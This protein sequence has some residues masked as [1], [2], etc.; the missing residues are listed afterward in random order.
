MKK[1]LSGIIFLSLLVSLAGCKKKPEQPPITKISDGYIYTVDYLKYIAGDANAKKR[2]TEDAYLIGVVVADEVTGNLYKEVYLRDRNGK[3]AIHLS[4]TAGYS[5]FFVGDSLR[6]MLK[7]YDVAFSDGMLEIDSIDYEKSVVKFGKGATVLPRQ[8]ELSQLN[9]SN[10]YSNYLCDLVQI[11]GVSFSSADTNQVWAD[12]IGQN[13]L[14]RIIQDCNGSQ[15]TVRTSNYA[16]FANQKTPKGY[17]FIIGVATAYGTTNQLVI[18]NP[19]EFNMTGTGC[20]IYHKKDF[21]DNSLTSGGWNQ[22]TVTNTAVV[23]NA[24]TFSTAYFAK[25]SGYVSGAN[26]NSEAWLISPALNLSAAINP[27]LSFQTAAKFAGNTLEVYV[28]TNYSSGAPSTATWTAL[29]GFALSPNNPGSY[30]WTPSGNLSLNAFKTN[31]VRVAFKYTSTT[32]GATTYE[33]D[34]VIIKEN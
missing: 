25:V 4:F 2:F 13:S 8:I 24:S 16:S 7:G 19:K 20:T 22:V 33:V 18:R 11:N 3:G 17:G 29:S 6:V 15:I 1:I 32:S 31:N 23:W 14:N 34:D 9:A 30:V 5:G 26:S 27:V 10:P 12:I 21:N 28:S